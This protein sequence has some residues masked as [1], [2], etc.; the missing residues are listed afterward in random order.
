MS[1]LNYLVTITKRQQVAQ[2]FGSPI[3]VVTEVALTP[4]T[5][6]SEADTSIRR[7]AALL[8]IPAPH[9]LSEDSE[10]SD[11]EVEL[12]NSAGDEVEDL[13]VEVA[14][15][16]AADDGS[17]PDSRRSSVAE[18][19]LR[20]RGSY[21]RFAQSWFSRSGWTQDQKRTMG[22]S[23][24]PTLKP[25]TAKPISA[26]GSM[27]SLEDGAAEG[28]TRVSTLL[29]K[30]LRTA[31][32]LFGTSRSFYFSYDVDITRNLANKS[33][34][35]DADTPLYA[36]VDSSFFWN[37]NILQPFMEAG[38]DSLVL[39]LMQGFVGQ[40]SFAVDSAPPQKDESAQESLELSSISA[41]G[42]LPSS[43]PAE[44]AKD[45]VELRPTERGY[46]VTV[47]SRRSTKRAGLR[48]LRRGVDENGFTANTVETEQILSPSV[49]DP[50]SQVY[51]F[52]QMRGSIPLFFSQSPY[53][54]KP[55]P[56]LQHSNETNFQACKKHLERIS[57]SYGTIQI[58]NLVEQ[59]G[60]EERIGTR[61]SRSVQ[62]YNDEAAENKK[63]P[64]EWFDFHQACRGMK[65]ENVSHLLYRLKDKLEEFGSTIQEEGS[66]ARKQKGVLRTNCM[67]CLDRT[68]VCQ[69]SFAKYM[70]ETQLREEG[71]DVSAQADQETAWFNTLWADNGDAVSKQYASTAAMKGDFTRTK[72]RNYRGALNDLGLSLTRFY[73]G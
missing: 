21:G 23:Q 17:R 66:V 41:T 31:R 60:I 30:L 18:D 34:F 38:H 55:V 4:C 29:P 13:P 64:F 45:A 42:S 7:T 49:W 69:S 53:S 11:D 50:S 56:V 1:R 32:I 10:A 57:R 27:V 70:L 68:N 8:K 73:N 3:Y 35:P 16:L 36:Q 67:D 51:S 24:S 44:K 58:V 61:F 52:L 39:P 19:V 59:H 62:R 14:A 22:I 54:L 6:K 15:E 9:S 26:S 28:T 25:E 20:K 47:I 48:Y 46:H 72:K 33:A 37:R 5:S 43:P 63:I 12:S 65:F 2:L 71:I 40:R